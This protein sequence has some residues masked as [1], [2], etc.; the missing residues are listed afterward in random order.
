M[1][2]RFIRTVVCI[3]V[4][5][6]TVPLFSKEKKERTASTRYSNPK[7][8]KRKQNKPRRQ[9]KPRHQRPKPQNREELDRKD[10]N[11][12]CNI[13]GHAANIFG[14]FV[15]IVREPH[16]RDNIGRQV[17]NM[18]QN[19]FHIVAHATTKSMSIDGA[20]IHSKDLTAYIL[21]EEFKEALTDLIVVQLEE[22]DNS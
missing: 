19:V 2:Y 17:G 12:I 4:I 16:N 9:N 13:L 3:S 18:A 6:T 15:N 11:R 7:Q 8:K 21:S 20:D 14:N 10:H 1:N 5:T 22:I